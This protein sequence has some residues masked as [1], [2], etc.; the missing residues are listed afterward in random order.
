MPGELADQVLATWRR[1]NEILLYLLDAIPREGLAAVPTGSRGRD[2][3][4]QFAHLARVRTGWVHYHTTG[5][6]PKL[7]R[8]DKG[9]RPT[10]AQLNKLLRESGVGVDKFLERGLRGEVRPR[11]FGKRVVRWMGYLIAH[12]SHHRGQILLALKQTGMRLPDEV[13]VQGV[14]GKWIYGQ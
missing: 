4:R 12:E 11:L 8:H 13:S 9:K 1:H 14:W 2:V 7:P 10:K 6:K 3:A 5:R